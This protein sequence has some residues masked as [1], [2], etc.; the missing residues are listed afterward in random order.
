MQGGHGGGVA[1]ETRHLV[2]HEWSRSAQPSPAQLRSAQPSSA[3][4]SPAQ[5]SPAQ[6]RA[7]RHQ[8]PGHASSGGIINTLHI[9]TLILLYS[10]YSYL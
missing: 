1:A 3:Q 5:P 10:A 6:L 8:K 2:D 4:P 7:A 9:Q